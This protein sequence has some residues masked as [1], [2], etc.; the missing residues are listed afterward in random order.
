MTRMRVRALRAGGVAL[1]IAL[2]ACSTA[3]PS[4]ARL[5]DLDDCAGR[6]DPAYMAMREQALEVMDEQGLELSDALAG[7]EATAKIRTVRAVA[8]A[9]EDSAFL[10]RHGFFGLYGGTTFSLTR[11]AALRTCMAERHGYTIRTIEVRSP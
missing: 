3:G 5:T 11:F 2:A 6:R 8:L 4:Q 7:L 1:A 10:K 9:G